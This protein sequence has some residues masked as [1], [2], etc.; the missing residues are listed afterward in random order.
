MCNNAHCAQADSMLIKRKKRNFRLLLILL[1]L[2]EYV[3]YT[4][5]TTGFFRNVDMVYDG[6]IIQ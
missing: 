4:I 1:I 6:K 5:K 3:V 2:L